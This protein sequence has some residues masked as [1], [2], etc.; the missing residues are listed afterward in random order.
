MFKNLKRWYYPVLF[1]F[2]FL[3]SSFVFLFVSVQ[4]V[5]AD[6][7]DIGTLGSQTY[8]YTGYGY[9]PATDP[10][11]FFTFDSNYDLNF[12]TVPFTRHSAESCSGVTIVMEIYENTVDIVTR[13]DLV[14]TSDNVS[15]SGLPIYSG[16]AVGID[17]VV[18]GQVFNF[19]SF[20]PLISG[21]EY[22]FLVEVTGGSFMRYMTPNSQNGV[23]MYQYN[24]PLDYSSGGSNTINGQFD[25][26][27]EE[28]QSPYQPVIINPIIFNDQLS[29]T[30]CQTIGTTTS[31][32]YS[33]STTTPLAI[34][35]ESLEH[36]KSAIVFG[37]G[38]FLFMF[39]LMFSRQV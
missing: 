25:V 16:S 14:A 17:P 21:V 24:T 37:I 18:D 27:L 33:Y 6:T 15:C 35:S 32:T 5:S 1:A 29:T 31:C 3:L 20:P 28:L 19:S 13:G 10:F 39:G 38:F 36:I 12:L 2:F 11:F 26:T 34:S 4:L 30:T 23:Q 9:S 7:V 8:A 22:M